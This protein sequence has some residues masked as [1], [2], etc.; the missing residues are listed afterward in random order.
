[1]AASA[2]TFVPTGVCHETADAAPAMTNALATAALFTSSSLWSRASQAP[3]SLT[4]AR[5]RVTRLASTVVPLVPSAAMPR[6]ESGSGMSSL[7][8][9]AAVFA[10]RVLPWIQ[11][12][13]GP[14]AAVS[15]AISPEQLPSRSR[16]LRQ[17]SHRPGRPVVTHLLHVRNV[18]RLEVAHLT[19]KDVDVDDV[20]QV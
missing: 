12:S 7:G 14:P 13:A 6:L 11:S 1:M 19:E 20:G 3:V 16:Q 4:V 10:R 5:A 15:T 18:H 8:V 2:T 9:H 17:R